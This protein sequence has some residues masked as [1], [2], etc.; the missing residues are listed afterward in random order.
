M[1][2]EIRQ[3]E[4]PFWSEISDPKQI[5]ENPVVS[6]IMLTYNH[7]P[8]LAEAIEGVVNQ[9]TDFPIE[10]LI[11]DDCST[12]NTLQV[13]LTYQKK[14]PYLIR[15][16]HAYSNS[17]AA[18]NLAR[19][20]HAC[21]GKFAALC[22]GDD[23]WIDECKLA[24]QVDLIR[25]NEEISIV[26][27][28]HVVRNDFWGQRFIVQPRGRFADQADK[29]RLE[30]DISERCFGGMVT[31]TSTVLCRSQHL[32]EYLGNDLVKNVG[33][34]Y[35]LCMVNY[36]A[37]R[38][39]ATYLDRPVSAYRITPG[40]LMR[41]G[42]K[43]SLKLAVEIRNF[44]LIFSEQSGKYSV[45]KENIYKDYTF[46]ILKCS[47]RIDD[48]KKFNASVRELKLCRLNKKEH[49]TLEWHKHMFKISLTRLIMT[50]AAFFVQALRKIKN[51]TLI[52]TGIVERV[53]LHQRNNK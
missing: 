3:I 15:V 46:S 32:K 37:L 24:D 28:D 33:F 45:N 18:V 36:L 14:Y 53:R 49:F 44:F 39:I 21:K 42:V 23:Y 43:G 38:G 7:G 48:K 17:G 2:I 52:Y 8:Y 13:A 29:A 6:V 10:L 22:E 5:P 9:K 11:G 4:Q 41:S 50:K 35:D 34:A 25:D 26:H 19:L 27:A 16:L 12:D 47:F 51:M 40:S 31:H 20:I 30:G 1:N